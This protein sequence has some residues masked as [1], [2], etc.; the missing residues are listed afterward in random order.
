MKLRKLFLTVHLTYRG[1]ASSSHLVHMQKTPKKSSFILHTPP[2][3]NSPT[4]LFDFPVTRHP[5]GPSWRNGW[6][7]TDQS[8]I[9]S[10]C[11]CS[12]SSMEGECNRHPSCQ[13]RGLDSSVIV[14]WTLHP[15]IKRGATITQLGPRLKHRWP[16]RL[17]DASPDG[18]FAS[19]VHR[20]IRVNTL[21]I[22]TTWICALT[23]KPC[24]PHPPQ[25]IHVSLFQFEFQ[26][27]PK[28]PKCKHPPRP[29]P[30]NA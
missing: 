15:I 20:D 2:Y 6:Q 29:S 18:S 7:Q 27:P 21:I 9:W 22:L 16:R 3:F 4:L 25:W 30:N 19:F 17:R 12:S 8:V 28:I 1:T 14:F 5:T 26:D 11:S 24:M 10:C 13:P 23:N